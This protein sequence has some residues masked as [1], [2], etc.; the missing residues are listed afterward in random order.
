MRG[1]GRELLCS[2]DAADAAD[3]AQNNNDNVH[4]GSAQDSGLLIGI[5]TEQ[6]NHCEGIARP[7]A[8]AGHVG[9]LLGVQL[10]DDF[11][12]LAVVAVVSH[13]NMYVVIFELDF[14]C[15]QPFVLI[16]FYLYFFLLCL[17]ITLTE[18]AVLGVVEYGVRSSSLAV[19]GK[20]A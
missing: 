6:R 8:K 15:V 19:D 16:P 1:Q 7:L 17:P 4:F 14:L 9:E 5:V 2:S 11:R 10:Q 3:A 12:G 20:T 13:S 18:L